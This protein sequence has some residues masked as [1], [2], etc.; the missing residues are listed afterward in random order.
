[1]KEILVKEN[2]IQKEQIERDHETK[3]RRNMVM[4]SEM[5]EIQK[6]SNSVKKIFL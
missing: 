1:M 5:R 4:R 2:E 3:R 6:I